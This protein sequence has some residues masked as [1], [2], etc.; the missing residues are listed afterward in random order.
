[1]AGHLGVAELRHQGEHLQL[2]GAEGPGGV[3]HPGQ[4]PGR[5]LIIDEP[6]SAL[7]QERG[8]SILELILKITVEHDTATVLVTHD[9]RLLPLMHSVH[10]LVDDVLSTS[11]T[12]VAG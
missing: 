9:Q 8:S 1:M 11:V 5:R 3:P 12:T 10:T 6:T 7:D 2:L 4:Q